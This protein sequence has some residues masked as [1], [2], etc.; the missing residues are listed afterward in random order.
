MKGQKLWFL[1]CHNKTQQENRWL[2]SPFPE[3]VGDA[4]FS[5]FSIRRTKLI[6]CTVFG[7]KKKVEIRSLN[8]ANGLYL[9]YKTF[10]HRHPSVAMSRITHAHTYPSAGTDQ[11]MVFH[12]LF[13][14]LYTKMLQN[15]HSFLQILSC[16]TVKLVFCAIKKTNTAKLQGSQYQVSMYGSIFG[17]TSWSEVLICAGFSIRPEVG[18]QVMP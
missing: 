15:D 3:T 17:F 12:F 7:S 9:D 16:K 5:L 11:W 13:S 18:I 14:L 4:A 1:V 2:L 10:T 8:K 6:V